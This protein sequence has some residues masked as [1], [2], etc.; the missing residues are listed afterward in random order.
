MTKITPKI[1]SLKIFCKHFCGVEIG[2]G[3][4]LEAADSKKLGFSAFGAIFGE[5]Q[6]SS[7]KKQRLEVHKKKTVRTYIC[8][9]ARS[10]DFA[11]GYESASKIMPNDKKPCL[12]TPWITF[13]RPFSKMHF[14]TVEKTSVC[15]CGELLQSTKY[16]AQTP[17]NGLKRFKT[18]R[19]I[20]WYA[21]LR[22]GSKFG[23][24]ASPVFF[25]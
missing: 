8:S 21:Y 14:F 7:Q 16:W 17:G 15:M 10:A 19:G 12:Q 2:Q 13:A 11:A 9:D 22:S 4:Q 20:D 25:L 1:E 18:S 3:G 24:T 5:L 23:E 6:V